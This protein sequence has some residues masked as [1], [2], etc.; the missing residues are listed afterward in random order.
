MQNNF[1]FRSAEVF[2]PNRPDTPLFY[3]ITSRMERPGLKLYFFYEEASSHETIF[4]Q[5]VAEAD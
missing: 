4:S 3:F 2:W 1:Q 5:S